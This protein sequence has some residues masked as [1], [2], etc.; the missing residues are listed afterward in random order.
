[1]IAALWTYD[2]WYALTASAGEMRRPSRDLPLAL[3]LGVGSA[4]VLYLLLNL[5]YLRALPFETLAGTTRVAEAAAARLFGEAGARWVSAA[6]VLSAFGCLASTILYSSR[7]YQPMAADGLFPRRVA[8]IHPR[9]HTPVPALWLQ[10]VWAL[11]LALTGS[12]NQ[13]FTY[14]TFG[15]VLFHVLAGLAVFRLRRTHPE[16]GRPYRTWGYPLVPAL[17]VLGTLA[18]LV[19]SL[20]AAPRESL[21][22]LFAIAAGLPGYFVWKR[23]ATTPGQSGP[24]ASRTA[25]S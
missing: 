5:V 18:V 8:A 21:L 6:V 12:Y 3:V 20:Q 22:G 23:K 1:M 25:S 17:F 11:A 13:L 4:I 15:G 16:A 19:N 7:M 24:G 2:G 9:W 14:V 10:S